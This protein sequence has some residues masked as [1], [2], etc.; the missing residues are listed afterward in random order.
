MNR[1]D[2]ARLMAEAW[3]LNDERNKRRTAEAAEA[4]KQYA[5]VDDPNQE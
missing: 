5:P 2:E 1:S 4:K 3:R